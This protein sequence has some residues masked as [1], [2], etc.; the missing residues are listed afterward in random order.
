MNQPLSED[1][2]RDRILNLN[3]YR[4][5][6][7]QKIENLKAFQAL[8]LYQ[9]VS[10]LKGD[11]CG[12]VTALN[13]YKNGDLVE[14]VVKWKD[15]TQTPERPVNLKPV[16][17]Q[18]EGLDYEESRDLLNLERKVERAFWE[19]GKALKEISDRKLYRA[20]HGTFENYCKARFGF[21]RRRPYQLM[22]AAEVVDNL[23][24]TIGTQNLAIPLPT[25][26]RQVRPTVGFKPETQVEIW[27]EAV[28][29]NLGRV[30][31]EKIVKQVA[32]RFKEKVKIGDL[33]KVGQVYQ[34]IPKDNEDLVGL[35]G[36]WCVITV[37]N[38]F[39]VQVK[40]C[41]GKH[42]AFINNLKDFYCSNADSK[43]YQQLL[44]RLSEIEYEKLEAT[45][46]IFIKAIAKVNRAAD[47]EGSLLTE[48]EEMVLQLIKQDQE[49][50]DQSY[51]VV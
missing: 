38:K 5:K 12:I 28:K 20:S 1:Q 43:A 40:T 41:F 32:A 10:N 23:M 29:A 49:C 25:T 8:W 44:E 46:K 50:K 16:V 45:Q 34:I 11:R 18:V 37:V 21:G 51:P 3:T 35:S 17:D 15:G 22:A 47:S 42:Q 27:S 9:A 7:A 2:K 13:S 4:E 39:S 6:D 33:F 30:P 19:A 26:E 24:C 36:V 48:F 14:A 31:T